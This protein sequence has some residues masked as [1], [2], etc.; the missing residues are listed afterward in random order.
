[1]KQI[2][3]FIL[4]CLCGA[5][6]FAAGSKPAF[7]IRLVAEASAE[8]TERMFFEAPMGEVLHVRKDVLLD[9]T[10]IASAS[11]EKVEIRPGAPEVYLSILFTEAGSKRLA[12]VTREHLNERIA[13][14]VDG[15]VLMAPVIVTPI[16]EGK[17]MISGKHSEQEFAALAARINAASKR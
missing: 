16:H 5:S 8:D 15:V 10:A 9:H 4:A 11:V 1:M 7:Q 3:V 6:L 17:V 13:C 14:I 2:L 12:E